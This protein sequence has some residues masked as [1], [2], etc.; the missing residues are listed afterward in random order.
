VDLRAEAARWLA[1]DP[2]ERT[3]A[4]LADL[5]RH[6]DEAGLADRFARRL[7]FGTAGMRGPIGAGPNRMNRVVVRR[8]TAGLAS[9][10][11]NADPVAAARGLV[12]GQDA[13]HGSAVFA[14]DT[15]AVLAGAR[16]GVQRFCEPVPTPLVAF[17]VRALE[18]GGGVQ[19]TASHN[20]SSDNGYKV[21][22]PG[23]AQILP[24]VEAEIS[25]AVTRIGRLADLPYDAGSPLIRPVPPWVREAYLD[26]ALG[27][28][29]HPEHRSLAVVYTP[30]HG[31]AGDLCLELLARA[32]FGDVRVVAEQAEPDPDFPTV[33]YP[34]PEQPGVLD[35]AVRLARQTGADLV[36]AN[37]PDGDR[38][39]AA[40]P[41]RDGDG[42]WR[43]LTGDEIGCLLAE[44]L[45]AARPGGP[46]RVVA[47]TVVS[48]Q[49]LAR[50]AE[51]HGAEYAETLTGFKWL[52]GV[53]ARARV[54]GKQLLLAYE[55]ALGV[56]VGDAVRDKD[57]IR[58]A[59][60]LAELAAVLKA[61]GRTL[62]DALDDLAC[63]HGVHAT[64]GWSRPI[65]QRE[66]AVDETLERLRV[67]RPAEVGGVGVVAFADHMEGKRHLANGS[68][69]PLRTPPTALVGLAL[70]DGS[71]LQIRPS[72]TEPLLKLYAEVVEPVQ[73]SS[74][75]GMAAARARAH[76]R[77]GMLRTAFEQ[78]AFPTG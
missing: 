36:I 24:P 72:G 6:G 28:V 8:V 64:A 3:R 14:E 41:E 69:E 26:T 32:G 30:L 56:M 16:I 38:I 65:E 63:R 66:A 40:V 75:T 43:P 71:R 18:A 29:H 74:A 19:I 76:R 50:I 54:Q 77:L 21:Y 10:L 35:L 53:A 22:G 78:L 5:L 25:A 31:V 2:D 15:A 49:L 59:L 62:L 52:A 39:A 48:S 58:A 4:E 20:P 33:P 44:Y 57:G 70:A 27:L 61:Q 46:G 67:A 12:V 68:V 7:E 23:G 55:Q 51:A 1:D 17:A 42:G 45:L 9:R 13:R 60:V 37:D 11:R 73:D 34:N 47:T